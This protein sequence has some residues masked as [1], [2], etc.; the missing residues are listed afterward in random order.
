MQNGKMNVQRS[1]RKETLYYSALWD[2]FDHVN[3]ATK[4]LKNILCLFRQNIIPE[5]I[6]LKYSKIVYSFEIDVHLDI[7]ECRK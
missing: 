5:F 4:F 7:S 2:L 3:I 6:N 1:L